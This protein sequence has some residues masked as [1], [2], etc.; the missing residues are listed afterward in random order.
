[1]LLNNL[2]FLHAQLG[3]SLQGRSLA[4]ESLR[5]AKELGDRYVEG[6]TRSTLA[7]IATYRG[8]YEAA[9]RYGRDAIKL[10][11][12]VS[13]PHGESMAQRTLAK[14]YRWA[15]AHE[16]KKGVDYDQAI[17]YFDQALIHVQAARAEQ[18]RQTLLDTEEAL[19]HM[20]GGDALYKQG[21]LENALSELRVAEAQIKALLAPGSAQALSQIDRA[22]MHV[23]LAQVQH[24]LRDFSGAKESLGKLQHKQ[25]LGPSY[26]IVPGE[27]LPS[28]PAIDYAFHPFSKAEWLRLE[29]ALAAG[30]IPEAVSHLTLAYAYACHYS[31]EA[32]LIQFIV[33]ELHTV[34]LSQA[35]AKDRERFM[36][37]VRQEIE[38]DFG[39]PMEPLVEMLEPLV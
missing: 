7:G 35:S 8:S 14:A 6:L 9:F 34:Y 31:S 39:V 5:K 15:G 32:V 22:N 17:Y 18:L 19:I 27:K 36:K 23:S 29:M 26:L 33:D 12:D 25:V 13:D 20:E 28:K 30:Q 4:H 2:A 24:Q 3:R 10:L 38:K 1:M 11:Q 21:G 37:L 16:A